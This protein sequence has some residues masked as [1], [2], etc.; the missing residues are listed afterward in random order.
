MK[1]NKLNLL[2]TIQLLIGNLAGATSGTSN[3]INAVPTSLSIRRE[4]LQ[5]RRKAQTGEDYPSMLD[6]FF[7]LHRCCVDTADD[8]ANF[9]PWTRE[10]LEGHGVDLNQIDKEDFAAAFF[11]L[12]FF[13]SGLLKILD[14]FSQNKEL[15]EYV[16]EVT[17]TEHASVAELLQ[18]I[19]EYIKAIY[20]GYNSKERSEANRARGR[21]IYAHLA[22]MSSISIEYEAS[23]TPSY[24]VQENKKREALRSRDPYP[25]FGKPKG[26]QPFSGDFLKDPAFKERF[27]S[28]FTSNGSRLNITRTLFPF[29]VCIHIDPDTNPNLDFRINAGG[30]HGLWIA[31]FRI[32]NPHLIEFLTAGQMDEL[33]HLLY[34]FEPSPPAILEEIQE[35]DAIISTFLGGEV[36]DREPLRE[37]HIRR[38][39]MKS[40]RKVVITLN[41]GNIHQIRGLL[42]QL[43]EGSSRKEML[44]ILDRQIECLNRPDLKTVSGSE[45]PYF[46]KLSRT[47]FS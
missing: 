27:A 8:F 35:L 34:R 46:A 6:R 38:E 17:G 19:Q 24:S 15:W 25:S 30:T 28:E 26:L 39:R 44:A 33:A 13:N 1:I 31:R 23:K 3:D 21:Y 41:M 40:I 18:E 14:A 32:T 9:K 20:N 22:T 29:Y 37:I 47:L 42:L 16:H 36:V 10:I 5:K 45:N 7:E 2:I 4:D 43:E 12:G 11:G